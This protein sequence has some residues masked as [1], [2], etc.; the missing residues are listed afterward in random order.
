MQPIDDRAVVLI[1]EAWEA[2]PDGVV[3]EGQNVSQPPELFGLQAQRNALALRY[4]DRLN[5][6]LG[7]KRFGKFDVFV[8]GD[9]ASK[10]QSIQTPQN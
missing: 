6:L 1:A 2:F 8:Q 7:S 9:F 3:P 4:R 10:F 5:D